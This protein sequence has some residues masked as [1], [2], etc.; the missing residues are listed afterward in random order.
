ME[1]ISNVLKVIKGIELRR[2][3]WGNVMLAIALVFIFT[4][5]II[6]I[7]SNTADAFS[8]A[9]DKGEQSYQEQVEQEFKEKYSIVAI[10]A[11]E[12]TDLYSLQRDY[13][14]G[15]ELSLMYSR[16]ITENPHIKNSFVPQG[17]IVYVIRKNP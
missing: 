6:S 17:S 10:L 2:V 8:N 4:N 5:G 9:M 13:L 14:E 16:T 11:N 1:K 7:T 15:K 3:R 12:N